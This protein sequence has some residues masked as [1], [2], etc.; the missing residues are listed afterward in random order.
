M[1]RT[2]GAVDAG[3]RSI[4]TMAVSSKNKAMVRAALEALEKHLTR[5]EVLENDK[6]SI[7]AWG[8]NWSK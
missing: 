4:L 7:S 1:K 6:L 5:D 3:A 8:V 2:V